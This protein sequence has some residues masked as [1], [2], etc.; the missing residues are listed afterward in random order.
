MSC[1]RNL[2]DPFKTSRLNTYSS[3]ADASQRSE[4]RPERC[5][6]YDGKACRRWCRSRTCTS[7][8]PI[9]SERALLE[10]SSQ[11]QRKKLVNFC[12]KMS[13]KIWRDEGHGVEYI[14]PSM[15]VITQPIF[16]V[17]WYSWVMVF[18]S[19][20]LSWARGGMKCTLSHWIWKVQIQG[21]RGYWNKGIS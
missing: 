5:R 17:S 12:W 7:S 19:I 14:L 13:F 16:S 10:T 6:R 20:S 11:L 9:R 8:W 18:G 4:C 3:R 2:V 21:T 1:T 15:P